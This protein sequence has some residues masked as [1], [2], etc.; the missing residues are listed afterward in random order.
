MSP[1]RH[2]AGPKTVALVRLLAYWR[3]QTREADSYVQSCGVCQRNK[4]DHVGP[5]R[6]LH[7][8]PFPTRRG[9]VGVDWLVGLPMTAAGFSQVQVRVNHLSGKFYIVPTRA[10][11]TAADAAQIILEM[12][13]PSPSGDG[14]PDRW[15]CWWWTTTPS[16]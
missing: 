14:V 4:V 10:T 3:G 13:L 6:L 16:S 7:P 5:R 1:Y 2:A 8:L 15:T 12:A 11:D 9:G